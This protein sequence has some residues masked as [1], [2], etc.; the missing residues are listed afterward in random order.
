[1]KAFVGGIYHKDVCTKQHFQYSYCFAIKL[2]LHVLFSGLFLQYQ[3]IVVNEFSG[4]KDSNFEPM[5][6]DFE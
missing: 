3:V 4:I 2:I 6:N 5:L 1:M